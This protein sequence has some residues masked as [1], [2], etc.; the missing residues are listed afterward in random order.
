M[1]IKYSYENNDEFIGRITVD[2]QIY[3]IRGYSRAGSRTCIIIP[4]LNILFDMGYMND[5]AHSID[6]KFISHGHNDH[7]GCLHYDHCTRRLAKI[8]KNKLYVMPR[9]CIKPYM[10]IAS[11]ISEMNRGQNGENIK[12]FDT[13][14]D[15]TIVSSEECENMLY[16]VIHSK[17]L[18]FKAIPMDHKVKSYAYI[19][20]RL[21]KKLK[22]EYLNMSPRE[23][24]EI[25]KIIGNDITEPIYTPI[26]AY[27]GDTTI[28]G[29]IK[30]KELLNVPLLI[31]EC[32]GFDD[33]DK[34]IVSCGGHIHFDDIV[35]YRDLFYNTK[36]ILFHFSQK[37]KTFQ[38]I[39]P[40]ISRTPK[41]FTDKLIYF[42]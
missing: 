39:E 15:T 38:D 36:I 14:L 6:N 5:I 3:T 23:L 30:N 35:A 25:K 20:Y 22:K 32:T 2:K 26:V 9:Q 31:M 24:I 33:D 7:I 12:I 19:I 41:S 18:F 21:S 13:L 42:L 34:D 10:M 29:I 37:Y 11:A 16:P 40:H 4:D 28:A 27:T 1:E 17:N 8:T